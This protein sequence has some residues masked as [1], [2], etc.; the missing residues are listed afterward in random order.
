MKLEVLRAI[1][2]FSPHVRKFKTVLDSR[3]RILVSGFHALK[4]GFWLS[5]VSGIPGSLSYIRDTKAQDSRYHKHNFPRIPES[6]SNK[7]PGFRI[8]QATYF[9]DSRIHKQQI[10]RILESTNNKFPGFRISQATNFLDSGIHKQQI[11]RIPDSTSNKFPRLWNP[12]TTNFPDSTSNKFPRFWIPQA[13]N[14]PDSGFHK[15]QITRILK[16]TSNKFPGFRISQATNFPDS[17]IHKQQISRIPDSS[18]NKFPR[19]WIPQATNYPDSGFWNP[20]ATNFPD[21]WI[22]NPDSLHVASFLSSQICTRLVPMNHEMHSRS[23]T[24]YSTRERKKTVDPWFT[25]HACFQS[26]V[27]ELRSGLII[28][29]Y[30]YTVYLFP[31]AVLFPFFCLESLCFKLWGLTL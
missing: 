28:C 10:S 14:F 6:T 23:C 30:K 25:L 2:F 13:T 16:S 29:F 1:C 7:F 20:Q 11:S 18:C 4:Y 24:F 3:Y 26:A 22:R 19:F 21:S 17:G 12:R 31:N 8:P 9:P 27:L 15:Q 5:I